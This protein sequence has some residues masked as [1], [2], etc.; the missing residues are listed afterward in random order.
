MKHRQY[1]ILLV[2]G[3]VSNIHNADIDSATKTQASE[4]CMAGAAISA[5]ITLKKLI[6]LQSLVDDK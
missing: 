5:A 3:F 2:S 1:Q 4:N 6:N